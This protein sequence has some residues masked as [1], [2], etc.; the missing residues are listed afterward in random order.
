MH[1]HKAIGGAAERLVVDKNYA[2]YD[3]STP[4][5]RLINFKNFILPMEYDKKFTIAKIFAK[6]LFY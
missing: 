4:G 6:K 5:V 1:K 2:L 3:R